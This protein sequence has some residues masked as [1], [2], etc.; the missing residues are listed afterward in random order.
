MWQTITDK[1]R[2]SQ[3]TA[4][5]WFYVHLASP[6][7]IQLSVKNIDHQIKRKNSLTINSSKFDLRQVLGKFRQVRRYSTP[8]WFVLLARSDR[9]TSIRSRLTAAM[10]EWEVIS[11]WVCGFQCGSV[12]SWIVLRKTRWSIWFYSYPASYTIIVHLS[13]RPPLF[14]VLI[15]RENVELVIYHRIFPHFFPLLTIYFFPMAHDVFPFKKVYALE[16]LISER[17]FLRD[18]QVFIYLSQIKTTSRLRYVSHSLKW[19]KKV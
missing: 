3:F 6:A 4:S 12:T 18:T 19:M 9:F 2:A 13:G 10:T 5:R 15:R 8:H 7:L 11:I 1:A 14:M 17:H 16:I